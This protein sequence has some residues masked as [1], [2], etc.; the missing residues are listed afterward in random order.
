MGAYSYKDLK[1]M[2]FDELA[3]IGIGSQPGSEA[4]HGA[5]FEINRRV[6]EAQ[7]EAAQATTEAA[8]HARKTAEYTRQAAEATIETAE[9]TR[10]NASYMLWSVIALV[11]TS[12][13]AI[14]T[15]VVIQVLF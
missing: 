8:D 7:L 14:V 3:E 9:Y 1:R 11:V 10:Q 6:A 13:L 5:Q 2:T 15:Q 4:S 12:A